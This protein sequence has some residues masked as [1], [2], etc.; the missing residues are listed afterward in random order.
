MYSNNKLEYSTKPNAKSSI[1]PYTKDYIEIST[2]AKINKILIY[3]NLPALKKYLEKKPDDFKIYY[4]YKYNPCIFKV[5][6]DYFDT[7]SLWYIHKYNNKYKYDD[8]LPIILSKQTEKNIKWFIS[9]YLDMEDKY[10][11]WYKVN[12][13]VLYSNILHYI[14]YS[15]DAIYKNNRPDYKWCSS[16]VDY[17]YNKQGK[18]YNNIDDFILKNYID[19]IDIRWVFIKLLEYHI[20]DLHL[21]KKIYINYVN[22]INLHSYKNEL[23][24]ISIFNFRKCQDP[25][26]LLWYNI[27]HPF[28]I[29]DIYNNLDKFNDTFKNKIF[30]VIHFK[31]V[32][33]KKIY[34]NIIKYTN[35]YK[36]KSFD[37]NLINVICDFII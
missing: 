21:L 20:I 8:I 2:F 27:L 30:I 31:N 23:N 4:L 36:H 17:D 14:L 26:I 15:P 3:K 25:H 12:F 32:Q 34:K 16:D 13:T 10:K 9:L 11:F 18:H 29:M 28:K 33:L 35:L 6:S 19:R 24:D 22:Y 1:R 7:Y 5:S 37:L